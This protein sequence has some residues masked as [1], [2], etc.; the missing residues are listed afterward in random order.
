LKETNRRQIDDKNMSDLLIL[1]KKQKLSE[2]G[3]HR[4][5][6][7]KRLNNINESCLK[8]YDDLHMIASSFFANSPQCGGLMSQRSK[9][10]EFTDQ[11]TKVKIFKKM[12]NFNKNENLNK[13]SQHKMLL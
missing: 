12:T 9:S 11:P 6:M 7:K 13:L 3:K 1:I 2:E 4:T 10:H 5:F 8:N